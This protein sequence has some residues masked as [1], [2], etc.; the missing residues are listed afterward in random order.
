M[1]RVRL[2]EDPPLA[3]KRPRVESVHGDRRQDDYS[4]LRE[5]SNPEVR[6]YLE[7]ENAYARKALEPT[8]ALQKI[9]YEE[10]VGRI[11]E[12]DVTVPYREGTCFYYTR[13][14]KGKQYPIHCRKMGSLDAPEEILLDLNELARGLQFVALGAFAVSDDQGL[15]AYSIDTT[16]FR[17]YTLHLK[18]LTDDR[19]LPDRATR[20]DSLAWLAECR[21]LLYTTQDA[22][23][24]PHRLWR[25]VVGASKDDLVREEEDERFTIRVS[26]TRSRRFVLASSES[27]TT[28]EVRCLPA[29]RPEGTWRV[30]VPR[31]QD[32]EYEVEHHGD[33][34]YIRINDTGRNFRLVT[35]PVAD[36][37][38]GNWR[39]V[40]P[41]RP[42]VMLEGIDFFESFWVA[43]ERER[44]LPQIRVTDL[45]AGDS[46]RLPFPE[47]AY[48]ASPQ[49]NREWAT[50]T[51]RYNYHSLVTPGSVFDYEI[52]ARRSVL[53]K[54]TEVLG[55]YDPARY[56]SERLH[57]RAQDG[58]EIP[59]SLVYR[60]A[61]PRDGTAPMLLS[62]YGSYGF[63]YPVA[64][65]S[66]RLSLLDRGLI[67]AIAH[68]RGGGELG[69]A[70]HDQGR[71]GHKTNTF[72]DFV[73]AA[74]HLVRERRTGASRLAI[75]G[76]SAG[77]L[78]MG[79]VTNLRPD[80]F[81]AVVS[82]VPFVD[83]VNTMLDP[84]LPL[85]VGEYEE[86]GNP[87]NREEYDTI[88]RYCPYTNLAAREYP[89]IL[90]RTSFNDSQVMYWE[91]AKYVAKLRTLKTD[92]RP[93]L[94]VTNMGG[95]HGG[96]SGR[97]D[98]LRELALDY[99]FVL[100]E[101]AG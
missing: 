63:S 5:R 10:M 53:R 36:P 74:E 71:M 78:L 61:T 86:W 34:F 69:K 19:I 40:L 62:G 100:G 48:Q 11:E 23:K 79:A 82:H 75:E 33:L 28:S 93:L 46:H 31:R 68:V 58:T 89:A 39:E 94:L 32:V 73:A 24:R 97:Y 54:R 59:I 83:V 22:S 56:S 12:T 25:H 57:A 13:T 8:E 70:W 90:V 17:E 3:P 47:P 37:R 7:A 35:A 42:D 60:K 14:E 96:S 76:G 99:A 2:L 80:L 9:L 41:H 65:S 81:R 43:C 18:D 26:R 27:H 64:F 38:S 4:W 67:V 6:A 101:T 30:V 51:F 84:S 66:S 98:K 21:T 85:T 49:N 29:D 16:G 45:L 44:G 52:D 77:G 20:V 50:R 92:R 72:T 88:K 1:E 95:G 15:L 87:N 55:G 91:P